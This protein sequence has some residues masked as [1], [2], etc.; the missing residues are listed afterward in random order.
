MSWRLHETQRARN[1]IKNYYNDAV[2]FDMVAYVRPM[3]GHRSFVSLFLWL[4][5]RYFIICFIA[6]LQQRRTAIARIDNMRW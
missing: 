2:A 1:A 6:H 3:L 4:L 5:I